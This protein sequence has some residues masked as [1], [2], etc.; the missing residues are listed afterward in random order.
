MFLRYFQLFFRCISGKADHLHPVQKRCRNRLCRIRG[1]DEQHIGQIIRHIHIVIRKSSVLFRIKNFQKR[2]GRISVIA[3]RQFVHFIQYHHRIGNTAL[4]YSVHDASGHR[5]DIGT[6]VPSD[7]RLIP[8]T[9]KA[10]PDIFSAKCFCDA[11]SDA[12]LPGSGCTDEQ[13]DRA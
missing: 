9:A 12:G 8:H 11:F 6:S 4:T 2:T 3:H 1:A 7:V 10:Y 5:P 13:E